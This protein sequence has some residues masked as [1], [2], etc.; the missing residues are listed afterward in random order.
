M[1]LCILFLVYVILMAYKL[2][3]LDRAALKVIARHRRQ[4]TSE[5]TQGMQIHYLL[6]FLLI[7]FKSPQFFA[8][9]TGGG[10]YG[11]FLF[12]QDPDL[13]A[14]ME[15]KRFWHKV[16]LAHD[17][18]HPKLVASVEN[19]QIALY[20][21]IDPGMS[22]VVKPNAGLG[23]LG[24]EF[25]D[26]NALLQLLQTKYDVLVQER[27]RACHDVAE[28]F[29]FVTLHDGTRF[30]LWQLQRKDGLISNYNS[31]KSNG[32]VYLCAHEMCTELEGAQQNA[33]YK[34]AHQLSDL[35]A[36]NFAKVFSIGWDIMFDCA[37]QRAYVL[38]GNIC[39][40]SWFYRIP[41]LIR[42]YKEKARKFYGV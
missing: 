29:R 32:K 16:F 7:P 5:A 9:F 1:W 42:D 18:P 21:A 17:V 37:S 26:G 23:G 34:L 40:A 28:S 25:V 36:R 14:Q 39:H 22:Y 11:I 10:I 12:Q 24:I 8:T 27:L 19:G 13:A 3:A 35:H 4:F 38:E 31:G 6:Q 20:D 33:I 30:V 15:T 2:D 41:A